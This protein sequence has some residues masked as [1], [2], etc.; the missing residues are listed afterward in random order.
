MKSTLLASLL[1]GDE[2]TV[3]NI[4]EYDKSK[5]ARMQPILI[6][7]VISELVARI[8]CQSYANDARIELETW[9]P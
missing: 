8:V 9:R 1:S 7:K 6:L 3:V 4:Q 2:H 5:N